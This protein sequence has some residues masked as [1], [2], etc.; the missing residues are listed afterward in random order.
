VLPNG[1]T[2]EYA[3]DR[4]DRLAKVTHA[5]HV[6]DLQRDAAGQ[7][8]GLT[9]AKKN[10]KLQSQHDAMGRVIEQLLT[11]PEAGGELATATLR[12]TFRYDRLGRI[13]RAVDDRWGIADYR[14]DV[15]GNLLGM[16]RG[17]ER[18]SAHQAFQYDAAGSLVGMLERAERK[19]G[20]E[21]WKL[22][23]GN[24]L[25]QTPRRKLVVD[26]RGRRIGSRDLTKTDAEGS[27]TEYAWDVRDRLVEARLPDGRRIAYRYDAFG[28]RVGKEV[29][30]AG[31]QTPRRTLAFVWSGN[32]LAQEVSNDAGVRSFVHRPGT[33]EPILQEERG[34]VFLYLNDQVG[35]PRELIDSGGRVAWSGR[36]DPWGRIEEEYVDPNRAHG[37][38]RVSS[39]FRLLG[40]VYDEETGLSWTRHRVFDAET[41][42]WLSPD[43]LGIAAGPNL[44]AFDGAPTV[45]VDPFGLTTGPPHAQ[46]TLAHIDAN[47]TA[48][49]G[50]RGGG[51]FANDGR[52]GGQ[53]LPQTDAS[54]APITYQEWDVHPHTPGVNRGQERIVT[55]SDGSA[56]YTSDHY[57][58]FTSMR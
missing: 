27:V 56:H 8:V 15:T 9:L 31:E 18:G 53:R 5:G 29:F 2:T 7:E 10:F 3:Y 39:P 41:G 14:Y 37:G 32:V 35:V 34:E 38:K 50:Y 55:G 1:S 43:P 4:A 30:H 20:A 23:P 24:V 11:V 42:R 46:T 40:Q 54:G 57:T 26:K 28:R 58:T 13:D 44:F 6:F 48:P 51:T 33:F 12:R 19:S 45:E 17:T 25:L 36:Y 52:G 49:A 16:T 22:G 21:P 47:G